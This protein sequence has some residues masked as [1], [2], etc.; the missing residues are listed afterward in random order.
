ML[1]HPMIL[2]TKSFTL[3]MT[4]V[5]NIPWDGIQRM[6]SD[7]LATKEDI[8]TKMT[9]INDVAVNLLNVLT[10]KN[11]TLGISDI[12]KGLYPGIECD[13][14]SL[15]DDDLSTI[16]IQKEGGYCMATLP[17]IKFH[18]GSG[19]ADDLIYWAFYDENT[20]EAAWNEFSGFLV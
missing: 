20:R 18:V 7:N 4:Y 19:R 11:L 9:V 13:I 16:G 2:R 17:G 15:S 6:D 1:K 8:K 3:D 5:H 12:Y 10:A 14:R